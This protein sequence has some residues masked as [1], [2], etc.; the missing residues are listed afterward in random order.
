MEQNYVTVTLCIAMFETETLP[1]HNM[2]YTWQTQWIDMCWKTMR[3]LATITE[4]SYYNILLLLS[5]GILTVYIV[6][7]YPLP[8]K[9]G[10]E[11]YSIH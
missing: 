7:Q 6:L 1:R 10:R 5:C 3:P 2:H 11:A 8:S 4:A 9:M